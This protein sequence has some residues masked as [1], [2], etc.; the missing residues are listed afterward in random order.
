MTFRPTVLNAEDNRQ[1]R[2]LGHPLVPG[3]SMASTTRPSCRSMRT[4]CA[5][6]QREVFKGLLVPPFARSMDHNTQR[7]FEGMN[8]ALKERAEAPPTRY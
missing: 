5:S 2:W 1:L 7:W 6:V 3:C 4:A 8:R